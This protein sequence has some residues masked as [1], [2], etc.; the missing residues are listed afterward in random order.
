MRVRNKPWAQPLIDAHPEI[1]TDQAEKNIGQWSNRF[2]KQ[3]PLHVE[4]GMGK[5][6]FVIGMAKAYPEINFIGLE[7]QKSVAATALRS[8]LEEQPLPNLQL[9]AGAGESIETYFEPGEVDQIYLN[10]SD[11]WPKKRHTKRRL[12]YQ[13][14]LTS[15]QK[16]LVTNGTLEL[17]TD[18]QGFFEYSL[19]SMN[20]FGLHFD[21][22]WLDLHNS[23][24]NENNV[25]TEY[26]QKFSEKG[27]PIYKVRVTF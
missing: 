14:F 2:Q 27:Q 1:I 23:E 24:E 20:N 9:I 18:N 13:S 8:A 22:V 19:V 12:T 10:F 15:Y 16:V 6:Q 17:K 3:Q 26:E 21:G 7:I 4:V 11:P 5:G 25:Q